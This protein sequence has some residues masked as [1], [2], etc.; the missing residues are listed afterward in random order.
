MGCGR[1]VRCLLRTY[2]LFS[3][4][5]WQ[6]LCRR[7]TSVRHTASTPL[8]LARAPRRRGGG[9]ERARYRQAGALAVCF[10]RHTDTMPAAAVSAAAPARSARRRRAPRGAQGEVRDKQERLRTAQAD[11]DRISELHGERQ[12]AALAAGEASQRERLRA[13]MVRRPRPRCRPRTSDAAC[14]EAT[15]VS[16]QVGTSRQ[17]APLCRVR[18][19]SDPRV[20]TLQEKDRA[21]ELAG[22]RGALDKALEQV[23][24]PSAA[25]VRC[26]RSTVQT[27]LV[28]AAARPQQ[29]GACAC[30][31]GTNRGPSAVLCSADRG[32]SAMLVLGCFRIGSG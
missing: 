22:V 9:R 2:V 20:R 10:M 28:A 17:S 7:A 16:D 8:R 27:G 21:V 30:G 23:P 24:A 13:F 26:C 32:P 31:G 14:L 25:P 29:R 1:I 5:G 4:A 6:E 12:A 11:S 19:A 15:C 18:V 3:S